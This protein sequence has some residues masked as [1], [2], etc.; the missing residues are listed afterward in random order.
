MSRNSV[1]YSNATRKATVSR[2]TSGFV[3]RFFDRNGHED[4]RQRYDASTW[5]EAN[6]HAK[7]SIM[8]AR[9]PEPILPGYLCPEG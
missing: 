9:T 2:E 3:V 6:E 8:P 1:S 5:A 4:K 7:Q